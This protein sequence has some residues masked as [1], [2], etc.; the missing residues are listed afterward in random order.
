MIGLIA[1]KLRDDLDPIV[2]LL[3]AA[4]MLW[5]LHFGRTG[6]RAVGGMFLFVVAL[7]GLVDLLRDPKRIWPAARIGIALALGIWTYTTI[8]CAILALTTIVLQ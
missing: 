1:H 8:R 6:F 7:D 3:V 2:C 4:S 5:M